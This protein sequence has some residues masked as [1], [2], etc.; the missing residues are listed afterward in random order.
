MPGGSF[1]EV[2]SPT[3]GGDHRFGGFSTSGGSLRRRLKD[4]EAIP[5]GI[6]CS[7]RS[8]RGRRPR[9]HHRLFAL[10]GLSTSLN[11]RISRLN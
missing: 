2:G 7:L 6:D 5:A 9:I 1:A 4:S 8:T 11:A 10:G 3:L